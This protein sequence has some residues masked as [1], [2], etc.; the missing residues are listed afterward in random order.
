MVVKCCKFDH[1]Q[2]SITQSMKIIIYLARGN[3][4]VSLPSYL[5]IAHQEEPPPHTLSIETLWLG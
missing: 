3:I 5:N 2:R 1:L 4:N